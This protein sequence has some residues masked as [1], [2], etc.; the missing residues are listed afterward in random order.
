MLELALSIEIE[1]RWKQLSAQTLSSG[2]YG[3]HSMSSSEI[4]I[5]YLMKTMVTKVM[6]CKDEM[7]V[8][9]IGYLF[10]GLQHVS[11]KHN[12]QW[13]MTTLSMVLFGGQGLSSSHVGEYRI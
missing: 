6:S 7:T 10:F 2:I 11:S 8:K 9:Q 3:L 13:A 4:E 5:C 1:H 12:K